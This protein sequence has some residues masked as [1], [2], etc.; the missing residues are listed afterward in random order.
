MTG[1]GSRPDPALMRAASAFGTATLHEAAGQR[2]AV[3]PAIK[4]IAKESRL[5]GPA[6]TVQSAPGDNLWLHRAIADAEP[7]DVLVVDVG[8]AYEYG[9]WGGLMTTAAL[10]R[11]LGGIVIDGCV[12][13]GDEIAASGFP[14]WARGLCIR[15]TTKDQRATGAINNPMTLAGVPIEPGDIVAGDADGVVI[16]AVADLVDV[17]AAAERRE[18]KEAG[19][20]DELQRGRTTLD[21]YG[22]R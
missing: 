8:G 16:I 17:L 20:I 5:C 3:S 10:E 7:G 13:D 15:G 2:G 14:V 4:P 6:V 1:V 12:R 9:Y 22:W 19:V 18:T 11:R 21:I